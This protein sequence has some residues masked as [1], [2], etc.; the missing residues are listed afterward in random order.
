MINGHKT[1]KL[2]GNNSNITNIRNEVKKE[3]NI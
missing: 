2:I 3:I 1:L